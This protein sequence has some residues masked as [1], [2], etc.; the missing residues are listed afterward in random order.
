MPKSYSETISLLISSMD[1]VTCVLSAPQKGSPLM[2]MSLLW[3]GSGFDTEE[4]L[5][6]VEA[7]G[8]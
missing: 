2:Q 5:R 1:L 6:N 8:K 7:A 3:L 4:P